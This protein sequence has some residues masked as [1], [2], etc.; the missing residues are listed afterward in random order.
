[1]E[2]YADPARYE[3]MRHAMVASQLRTNSV[4][5]SGVVAAMARIPR[6][7]Y[8]PAGVAGLAYRDTALPLGGGREANLP[9]ATGRLLTEAGIRRGEKVLLIGAAGGYA[10]ALI[11]ALGAQVVAVESDPALLALATRALA[12]TPGVTLVDGPLE[13]GAPGEAPFDVLVVDGAVQR[14][15]PTLIDQLRIGGRAV[16]GLIDRGVT[17]LAA[18]ART[19]GGFGL[20]PFADLDCVPLPGFAVPPAFVF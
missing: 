11:V 18:G 3:K 13:A 6:E 19:A 2:S 17:R 9:V 1:M 15:P 20:V 10:A 16:S 12:S 7:H 8:L 5:D 4:N 14:V